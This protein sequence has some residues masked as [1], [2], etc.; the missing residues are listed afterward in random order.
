MTYDELDD[1]LRMVVAWDPAFPEQELVGAV[2]C[3]VCAAVVEAWYRDAH[4][5]YHLEL[6]RELH[7]LADLVKGR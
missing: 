7:D 2:R 4:T 6:A 3:P 5:D 1:A